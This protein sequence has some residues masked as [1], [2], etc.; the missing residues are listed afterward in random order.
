MAQI[1]LIHGVTIDKYVGDAIMILFGEP[2]TQGVKEDALACVKMTIAMRHRL[3]GLEHVWR[4]SGIE[5]PLSCRMG[6]HTGFCTVGNFGSAVNTA[7]RLESLVKPG[8]ILI[9]F[10]TFAHVRDLVHCEEYGQ[11][12]VKGIA[13]PVATYRSSILSRRSIGGSG[14]SAPN[15]SPL[16]WNSISTP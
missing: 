11:A 5:K 15:T 10:E 13:Y 14:A 2:E 4:Q 3:E 9:S 12:E 8:E 6:T 7:S 1:A 16:N